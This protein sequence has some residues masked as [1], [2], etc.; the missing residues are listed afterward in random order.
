M[1]EQNLI[2]QIQHLEDNLSESSI[3]D[4]GKL[5][6]DLSK[7]VTAKL[8]SAF[9]F[10]TRIV[11]FFFFLNPKLQASSHPLWLHRQLCVAPCRKPRSPV[12]SCRGLINDA[13][14]DA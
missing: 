8:I 3:L 11:Q 6:F 13:S 1:Y 4:I 7:L 5:K 12:I 14:G 2:E 9:A 10:A